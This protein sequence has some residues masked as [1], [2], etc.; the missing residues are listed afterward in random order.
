MDKT[1]D[2]DVYGWA[3]EQADALKRR[4]VNEVDWDNV[5]EEIES[6]GK[7]EVAEFRSR[8]VILIAHLLKWTVQP[9]RRTRSWR[10]TIVEQRRAIAIH[11]QENPSLRARQ[12]EIFGEAYGLA[13]AVAARET[14]LDEDAFPGTPGF[15]V[16]AAMDAD[17]WPEDCSGAEGIKR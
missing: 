12:D 3:L 10:L 4:A 1:Y 6:L 2:Q 11:L 9:D 15:T 8:L 16:S 5:A 14:D 17:W 13:L 7:R